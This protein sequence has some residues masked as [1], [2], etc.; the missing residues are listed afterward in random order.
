MFE[1]MNCAHKPPDGAFRLAEYQ[2]PHVP[3]FYGLPRP[4]IPMLRMHPCLSEVVDG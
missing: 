4:K 2:S 1:D 3:R